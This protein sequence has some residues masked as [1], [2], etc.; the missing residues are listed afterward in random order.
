MFLIRRACQTELGTPFASWMSCLSTNSLSQ[1]SGDPGV[2]TQQHCSR[3]DSQKENFSERKE[4]IKSVAQG[5]NNER[6]FI[7]TLKRKK[8]KKAA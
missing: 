8:K 1:M 7:Q 5:A 4:E 6:C 3:L 2:Q